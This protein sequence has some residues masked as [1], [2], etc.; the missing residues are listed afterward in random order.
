VPDQAWVTVTNPAALERF[1]TISLELSELSAQLP[2][3]DPATTTVA[4]EAGTPIV[5]QWLD[6][7]ADGQPDELLFQLQ[8]APSQSV[9]VRLQRAQRTTPPPEQYKVYGRF[10]RERF[11]DFA[12][13]NDRIAARMYGPALE[14]AGKEALTSSGVDA[15]VKR[16]PNRVIDG[17]YLTGD[18]H[19]DHGQGGDFYSVGTSRGCGGLGI[20]ANGK[21]SVSKNFT[22]SRV[23]A[24]GPI[25]LVFELDYA[26]WNSG[27]GRVSETKRIELDAG[28]SFNH[29]RSTFKGLKRGANVALGIAKHEGAEFGF[30]PAWGWIR[31]WEPLNGGK[32]GKL[33]CAVMV[34]PGS[35]LEQRDT[36]ANYLLI[37]PVPDGGQLSFQSGW[38]WDQN[39]RI[40]DGAAWDA[41]L[42]AIVAR[43][44]SPV[45]VTVSPVAAAPAAAPAAAGTVVS[46]Q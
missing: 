10:V 45:Q 6:A 19:E 8:L 37:T 27:A 31:T 28:S 11:D 26:P 30:N 39:Q 34:A 41:E 32:D 42:A 15:W 13:E 29:V 16:G 40:M 44:K 18:Y 24:S 35:T 46:Q 36:D 22:R 4:D 33:G 12:W 2:G 3:L 1:E 23:L 21:L 7:D 38:V 25:R 9:R 43:A 20:W 17:W 14:K 5:S